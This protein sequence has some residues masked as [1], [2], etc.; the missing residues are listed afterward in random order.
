MPKFPKFKPGKHITVLGNVGSGKTYATKNVFIVPWDRIIVLDSEEDDYPEFPNVSAKRALK[1]AKSDYAFVVR[2]PTSG[3]READEELL[4]GLCHG[5]LKD[6]HDLLLVIE[7]ATDYSDASYIPPYLRALMRRARHR[8]ITVLISTQRPAMMS[9]DYYALSVHHFFFFL[10]D[11]DTSHVKDY[12]KFLNERMSEI[13][14]ESYKCLYQAP[15]SSVT[16][17]EPVDEYDWKGRLKR[18]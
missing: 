13:P 16:V 18:N 9:K 7:E 2:I 15:D 3:V 17:L 12:A 1:L 4:E 14:Y 6:G 5:L 11:Y 10:S 8:G